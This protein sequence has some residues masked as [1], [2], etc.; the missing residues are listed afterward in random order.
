MAEGAEQPYQ[1]DPNSTAREYENVTASDSVNFPRIARAVRFDVGGTAV[2]V[3]A[4]DTTA[5][6]V[7]VAGK[8]EPYQCKRVNITGTDLALQTGI[9]AV[10]N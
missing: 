7:A 2:L 4:D 6:I 9:L 8:D 3:K 1:R 10:Y 5:T